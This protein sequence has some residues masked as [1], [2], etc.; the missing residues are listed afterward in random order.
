MVLWLNRNINMIY[1]F[2]SGT[3]LMI[4]YYHCITI[5]IYFRYS[6]T[7]GIFIMNKLGLP[8]NNLLLRN[9][10]HI[11]ALLFEKKRSHIYMRQTINPNLRN[12]GNKIEL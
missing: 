8:E 10:L 1:K 6:I 12:E 3:V 11:K 4:D 9:A 7:Q 5:L 2:N